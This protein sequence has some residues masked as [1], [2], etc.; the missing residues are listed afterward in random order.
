MDEMDNMD[1]KDIEKTGQDAPEAA[2][3]YEGMSKGKAAFLKC[4]PLIITLAC[5][6]L[7]AWGVKA[8]IGVFYAPKDTVYQR[9]INGDSYTIVQCYQNPSSTFYI[10]DGSYTY[11]EQLHD[12]VAGEHEDA[13]FSGYP[14]VYFILNETAPDV[15]SV[16]FTKL[17][18]S[19]GLFCMQFDEFVLY[20][21][22]GQYGV[23][24]PLRDYKESATSRKNDL[25]VVRQLLK[26]DRYK[27][28]QLP[29][30]VTEAQFLE[31][32]EKLEWHLDAQYVEDT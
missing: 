1:E 21:L 23:F 15:E 32:L 16:S 19:N 3:E 8:L 20:R 10:Y 13:H 24:A 7:F 25:Y 29:D 6:G 5:V 26:D 27:A 4:L 2:D 11:D 28:F 31:K 18:E 12:N 9:E 30:D 22:E 14:L 17:A